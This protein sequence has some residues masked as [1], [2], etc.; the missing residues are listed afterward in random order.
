MTDEEWVK[1]IYN[2]IYSVSN[3]GRIRNDKTSKILSTWGAGIKRQYKYARVGGSKSKKMGIHR[4]VAIHFIENPDNLPVVDHIDRNKSNNHVSN[5]R[6]ST[7]LDNCLNKN[8]EI[9]CRKNKKDI[10]NEHCICT[11]KHGTFKVL[12]YIKYHRIYG[13]FK[14]LE[15]AI[16]FRDENIKIFC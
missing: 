2:E 10:N 9:K 3:N 16:K 1:C 13:T 4:L 8:P 5:L 7:H 15:D 14:T 11:S 12:M 6:W